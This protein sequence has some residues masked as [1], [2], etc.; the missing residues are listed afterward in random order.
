MLFVSKRGH[1]VTDCVSKLKCRFCG[2]KHNSSIHLVLV[3]DPSTH[4]GASFSGGEDKPVKAPARTKPSTG[5]IPRL[6]MEKVGEKKM[7][8]TK[9]KPD[10][11][12]KSN[13]ES[14]NESR[15]QKED[16]ELVLERLAQEESIKKDK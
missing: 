16:P 11:G 13:G 15:G 1:F 7:G 2:G 5:E 3:Q 9:E 8:Q 6:P 14:G 12:N 10:D 4:E